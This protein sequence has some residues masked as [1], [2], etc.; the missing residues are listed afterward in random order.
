MSIDCILA[1]KISCRCDTSEKRKN[2]GQCKKSTSKVEYIDGL[3][4]CYVE[5]PSNCKDLMYSR[6]ESGH[7]DNLKSKISSD[8]CKNGN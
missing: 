1:A 2:V 8:A 3:Y 4:V 7:Y 6:K 5:E